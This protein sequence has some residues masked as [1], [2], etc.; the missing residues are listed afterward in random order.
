MNEKKKFSESKNSRLKRLFLFF[1]IYD[2]GIKKVFFSVI[3][4]NL[5]KGMTCLKN[6]ISSLIF[7]YVYRRYRG[8][9]FPVLSQS[10][11]YLNFAFPDDSILYYIH[12]TNHPIV[13]SGKVPKIE[14]H[15]WSISVYNTKGVV[16]QHWDDCDLQD[17]YQLLIDIMSSS[18]II[19]RFYLKDTYKHKYMLEYLPKVSPSVEKITQKI[20]LKNSKFISSLL[21]QQSKLFRKKSNFMYSQFYLPSIQKE[22]SL[23]PNDNAR[24]CIA[25]PIDGFNY[26]KITGKLPSKI[27]R[28]HSLRFISF[29]LGN[30]K[31]T[32]TDA[33]ISFEELP[34]NYTIWVAFEKNKNIV[35]E[36]AS[37]GE[38]I[39]LWKNNSLPLLVYREVRIEK[40]FAFH[41]ENNP[42]ATKTEMKSFYPKIQNFFSQ[43]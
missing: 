26:I 10:P 14:T 9:Y 23:F 16:T 4:R 6:L 32:A 35:S 20:R 30:L 24:Y 13:L 7:R 22:Q 38:P 5:K 25:H 37:P 8:K 27:G 40:D 1:L 3:N 17:D 21:L 29:M 18:C 11:K 33:S 43:K 12:S 42:E 41:T 39:L 15:F 2:E 19:I 34:T 36:K 31:T 28:P